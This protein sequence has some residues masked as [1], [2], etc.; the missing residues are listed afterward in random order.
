MLIWMSYVSFHEEANHAFETSSKLI[1]ETF[2]E[3]LRN[4]FGFE[5]MPSKCD[6]DSIIPI[7][8]TLND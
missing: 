3:M 7:Y 8:L 6:D 1:Q 4:N 5:L 2:C